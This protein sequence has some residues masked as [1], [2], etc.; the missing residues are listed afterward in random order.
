MS[1]I[2]YKSIFKYFPHVWK[3]RG[4]FMGRL[5]NVIDRYNDYLSNVL[6]GFGDYDPTNKR[7]ITNNIIRYMLNRTQKIFEWNGLP[8][9]IPQRIL[10]SYLQINGHCAFMKHENQLYIYTGGLGGKPDVYYRP[11][12]YTIAN[13][14]QNISINAE[15]NKDCVVVINDSYLMGLLPMC[16][17]YANN[18]SDTEISLYIANINSRIISLISA[19]DDRTEKSAQKYISDIIEGKIGV[20]GEAKFF[21]DLKATPFSTSGAHAVITD[22]IELMQYNKASFFNEIGLNANYNMKRESINSNESQLNN[23]ALSPLIDDML[24]CRKTY[25]EKVNTMFDTN[26]TVD[27]SSSWK[28]NRIEE[29]AEIENIEGGINDEN[30][31]D[32][33]D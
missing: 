27:L 23:D 18:M 8:D 10:E 20:I 16:Q 32:E 3:K 7:L 26:I 17:R 2:D 31:Q 30:K 21:E 28:Q 33:I 22:L 4:Y 15:I 5:E 25:I 12:I 13:P 19:Q 14:A 6:P 24:F 9:T 11:T 29:N 1:N